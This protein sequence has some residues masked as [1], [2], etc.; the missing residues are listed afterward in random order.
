MLWSVLLA[1]AAPFAGPPENAYELG[2][3]LRVGAAAGRMQMYMSFVSDDD[4]VG[5]KRLGSGSGAAASGFVSLGQRLSPEF[6][7]EM[8][9][10]FGY[11]PLDFELRDGTH[12][13]S[14][15]RWFGLGAGLVF[16][17]FRPEVLLGVSGVLAD[18]GPE[19]EAT[20]SERSSSTGL[21]PMLESQLGYEWS[22]AG[23]FG[24]GAGL[25]TSLLA[26][27]D[28]GDHRFRTTQLLVGLI[29]SARTDL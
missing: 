27:R 4:S 18:V 14:S 12:F 3:V 13:S 1:T 5:N 23:D 25:H 29:L 9:A 20:G 16:H 26:T 24:L 6:E 10:S 21:S 22:T 15:L 19:R 28:S 17:P 2:P 7:V 11:A 8:R